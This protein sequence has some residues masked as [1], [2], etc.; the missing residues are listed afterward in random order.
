MPLLLPSVVLPNPLGVLTARH[1]CAVGAPQVCRRRRR[2]RV[3][4]FNVHCPRNIYIRQE[5]SMHVNPLT[6]LLSTEHRLRQ[7]HSEPGLGRGHDHQLATTDICIVPQLPRSSAQS[8]STL[9][10]HDIIPLGSSADDLRSPQS[11]PVPLGVGSWLATTPALPNPCRLKSA[12]SRDDVKF[13]QGPFHIGDGKH[14]HNL[15]GEKAQT[16]KSGNKNR[17]KRAHRG[18]RYIKNE[19]VYVPLYCLWSK[20]ITQNCAQ[21]APQAS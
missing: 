6:P 20:I 19:C 12:Q 1:M 8:Q 9:T 14:V 4:S 17:G 10:C 15:W 16:R 18:I 5:K 11:P 3:I 21:G 7:R 13:I 2:V